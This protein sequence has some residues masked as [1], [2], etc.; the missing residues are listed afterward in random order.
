MLRLTMAGAQH[1][2]LSVRI[3]PPDEIRKRLGESK[4]ETALLKQLL[5]L[6]EQATGTK[7]LAMSADDRG[8]DGK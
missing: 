1:T 2:P 7:I 5:K 6:S 8:N 4:R 3:P